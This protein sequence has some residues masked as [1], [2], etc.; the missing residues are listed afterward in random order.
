MKKV[1]IDMNCFEV[2][3]YDEDWNIVD[4]SYCYSYKNFAEKKAEELL[5]AKKYAHVIIRESHDY[6]VNF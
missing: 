2:F 6:V 5:E 4:T 3:V 1:D